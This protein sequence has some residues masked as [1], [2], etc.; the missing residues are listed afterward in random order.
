M[1]Y[2]DENLSAQAWAMDQV[3]IWYGAWEAKELRAAL[4]IDNPLSYLSNINAQHGLTWEVPSSFLNTAKRF[5]HIKSQDWVVVYFE[6][7]L[8]LA[9]IKEGLASS[10]DHPLNRNG[11][12]FKFRQITDKKSFS[13]NQLPDAFRL[14]SS[15]GRGNVFQFRNGRRLIEL[16]GQASTAADVTNILKAKSL[17][18]TLDLLGPT[19]WESVCLTYL[20]VNCDFVPAVLAVGKTL[21]DMDIVGRRK[22]DGARILAQCKKSPYP[23][24]IDNGF[25]QA[26]S[27]LGENGIAFYF[28]YAGCNGYVP[29]TIT[30]VD[31]EAIL[32]WSKTGCGER[33][34]G[35]LFGT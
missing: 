22:S 32:A 8:H 21:A 23:I 25:L 1:K 2:G 14:L 19:A 31:R 28:A 9:H 16:L 26:I 33:Y 13:L 15:A 7:A 34:F 11:E 12:L 10:Q 6:N 17:D 30:I 24:A 4:K 35:W 27:D 20:I 5:D 18:E 29:N 3:G